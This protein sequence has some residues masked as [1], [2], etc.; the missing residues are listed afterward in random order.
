MPQENIVHEDLKLKEMFFYYAKLRLSKKTKN[1][2]IYKRIDKV[3]DFWINYNDNF[4]LLFFK[5][6][7]KRLNL[8]L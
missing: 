8:K 1:D 2:E 4:M 3:F 5:K 6:K 7:C